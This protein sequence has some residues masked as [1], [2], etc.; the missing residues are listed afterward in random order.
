MAV[1][2]SIV[3]FDVPGMFLYSPSHD[4][5]KLRSQ[6]YFNNLKQKLAFP[7]DPH[8]MDLLL[9]ILSSACP[10]SVVNLRQFKH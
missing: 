6:K 2:V 4:I 8:I 1:F 5:I 3:F 9:F 10:I 7:C